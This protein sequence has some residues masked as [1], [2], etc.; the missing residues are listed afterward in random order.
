M[1]GLCCLGGE[2]LASGML[3][4]LSVK[5][6]TLLATVIGCFYGEW[7]FWLYLNESNSIFFYC[8][9]CKIGT[10]LFVFILILMPL[11]KGAPKG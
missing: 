8:W 4:F 11:E 5:N 9:M 7:Y 1:M 3:F 2:G 10:G 6:C